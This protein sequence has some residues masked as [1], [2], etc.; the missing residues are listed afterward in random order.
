M[1]DAA[2]WETHYINVEDLDDRQQVER[3]TSVETTVETTGRAKSKAERW[4][5]ES[6]LGG[7]SSSRYKKNLDIL[8]AH[9][10]EPK[11]QFKGV[12][13]EVKRGTNNR[14]TELSWFSHLQ[15]SQRF[16]MDEKTYGDGAK[17]NK[18]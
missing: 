14:W 2:F 7:S 12:Y 16:K 8:V 9:N 6:I 1:T 3:R 18:I 17:Q 13:D 5:R 4:D 15:L 11:R 10:L